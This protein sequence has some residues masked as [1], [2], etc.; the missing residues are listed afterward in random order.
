VSDTADSP[1]PAPMLARANAAEWS[2]TET[3]WVYD[4]STVGWV[5]A[6]R[7]D[8]FKAADWEGGSNVGILAEDHALALTVFAED[9][10]WTHWQV[11]LD[12]VAP[13]LQV[14]GLSTAL[15][16]EVDT[17]AEI[18]NR[19]RLSTDRV[20]QDCVIWG[21]RS[22]DYYNVALRDDCYCFDAQRGCGTW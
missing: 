9:Q 12:V 4:V 15:V 14:D 2:C 3:Q 6:V 7:L 11:T 21:Q 18:A 1:E 22:E 16:C 13:N 10:S 8:L 20:R 17:P 19:V 5:D